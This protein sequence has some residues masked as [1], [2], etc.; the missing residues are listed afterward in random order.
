MEQFKPLVSFI[1]VNYN[2]AK[3]TCELLESLKQ[4]TY[5]NVEVII[6]DNGSSEDPSPFISNA[7]PE[8]KLI[9]SGKNLGF[10]GGNNIGIEAAK[11]DYLFF[12]NNDTEVTPD[13]VE[14]L[15]ARFETD[16]QIGMI[17]PKIRYFQQ[18]NLIQYAGYTPINP[19][20]ARNNAIGHLEEDKG[21][22]NEARP[23][24]YAHGAAM[25]VKKEVIERVGMMPETFFLYYE[26]LDWC[27][28]IRR[29][30]YTIYYEPKSLIYHKE[31]ISV[32]KMSTLKTYYM[33]RNRVLFMRRN[34]SKRHLTVFLLF[35]MFLTVPK[36]LL[37]Y[38]K[39]FELAHIKAFFSG[40]LWNIK[41]KDLITKAY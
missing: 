26:E 14:H 11:G 29:G 20:T 19:Y 32:G 40:L 16:P 33:A 15:L 22:H 24:A 31:S 27:E 34:A 35:L 36:N 3:V 25:M 41:D 30:G 1:S 28:Q 10:A 8:T 2:Q 38:L 12:V 39:K 9:K 5:P 21:Q 13:I 17:S 7:Y 4:L 23:T 6:V 18:P 37:G